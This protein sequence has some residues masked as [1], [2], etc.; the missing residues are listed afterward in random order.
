MT[1]EFIMELSFSLYVKVCDGSGGI[2]SMCSRYLNGRPSKKR[3]S[4]PFAHGAVMVGVSVGVVCNCLTI[5]GG[6]YRAGAG[7]TACLLVSLIME[8]SDSDGAAWAIILGAT[9]AFVLGG[10][11]GLPKGLGADESARVFVFLFCAGDIGTLV[12][13]FHCGR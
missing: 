10:D 1:I 13:V 6:G 8:I 7:G 5:G 11:A 3:R 12:T 9:K 4:P 2:S